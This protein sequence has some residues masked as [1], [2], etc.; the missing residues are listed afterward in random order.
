MNGRKAIRSVTVP[1]TGFISN[2]WTL[3][4]NKDPDGPM[5]VKIYVDDKLVKTFNYK[6]V[7][8]KK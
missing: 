5:T 2:G 3:D 1:N 6:I 7:Q 8:L 4:P